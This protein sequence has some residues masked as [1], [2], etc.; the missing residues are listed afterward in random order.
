MND[1]TGILSMNDHTGILSMNGYTGS[2]ELRRS[3]R[4][5]VGV[6]VSARYEHTGPSTYEEYTRLDTR[7]WV[8]PNNPSIIFG[9]RFG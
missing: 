1:D 3:Y 7:V 9:G 2:F 5:R 8:D 4:A 6:V